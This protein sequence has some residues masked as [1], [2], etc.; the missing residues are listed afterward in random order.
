MGGAEIETLQ[1]EVAA[2][3]AKLDQLVVVI[4][5]GA[6]G[7]IAAARKEAV[8]DIEAAYKKAGQKI[9]DMHT[10]LKVHTELEVLQS[11]LTAILENGNVICVVCTE[12]AHVLTDKRHTNSKWIASKKGYPRNRYIVRCYNEHVASE[13]HELCHEAALAKA[14][15]EDP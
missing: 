1:R 7:Q 8:D 3:T 5:D 2:L 13:G 14:E 12:N 4:N 11:E 10:L 6:L 9:K 15:A